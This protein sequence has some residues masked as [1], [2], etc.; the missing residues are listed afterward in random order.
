MKQELIF[1]TGNPNKLREA[2]KILSDFTVKS[3]DIE[4]PEIQEVNEQLIVEEKIRHALQLLD[5]PVFVEDV[6][7]CYE[8][9][10]GL[11][12]PLVKWFIKKI[13]RRGLVDMLAAY[14]NKTAWAKCYVGYGIPARGKAKEKIF[15]FEGSVKGR[16]VEPEGDSKFGFDPIF[17]PDGHEKTF[18]QMTEAE[19]NEISHRR[20]ALEKLRDFLKRQK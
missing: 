6:S 15:V 16:I 9:L 8:S 11:P 5:T 20:L 18:A 13:G 2:R 3:K 10:N 12:G 7:L 14:D 4:L 17:L 1:I 19:K